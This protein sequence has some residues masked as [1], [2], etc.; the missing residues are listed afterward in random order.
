MWSINYPL[1]MESN[2]LSETAASAGCVKQIRGAELYCCHGD[3]G[4][5]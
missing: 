4:C 3:L 5:T 2:A 1:G